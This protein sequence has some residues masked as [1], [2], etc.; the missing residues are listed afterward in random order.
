MFEAFI[1]FS[2]TS[3]GSLVCL[4]T[5]L[6]HRAVARK[7]HREAI[8]GGPARGRGAAPPEATSDPVLSFGFIV[9]CY[10]A[11]ALGLVSELPGG[12]AL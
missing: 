4:S 1:I 3:V 6:A 11:L 10:G 9:A 8:A 2:L 12:L 7:S 5:E